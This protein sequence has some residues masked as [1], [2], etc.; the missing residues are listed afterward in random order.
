MHLLFAVCQGWDHPRLRGEHRTALNTYFGGKGSPPPTRGTLGG[1]IGQL[2]GVRITPAYAGNTYA[3]TVFENIVRDH[4]RLRGEH[5][6][7]I[8]FVKLF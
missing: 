7:F 1:A 2:I 4:P 6:I 3:L 8:K 5:V